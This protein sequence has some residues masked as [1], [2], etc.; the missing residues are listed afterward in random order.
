MSIGVKQPRISQLETGDWVP[1]RDILIHIARV[2]EAPEVLLE[3]LRVSPILN[4][5]LSM[6]G[7]DLD[8]PDP[9]VLIGHIRAELSLLEFDIES[10]SGSDAHLRAGTLMDMCRMLT[11][12]L[13]ARAHFC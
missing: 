6:L 13:A 5:A 11:L 12:I 8:N 1:P 10:S 9:H 2:L 7:V 4:E 3:A